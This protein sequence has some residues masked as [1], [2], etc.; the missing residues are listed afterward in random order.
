MLITVVNM[1]L[2][3]NIKRDFYVKFI[4]NRTYVSC[5]SN[6]YLHMYQNKVSRKAG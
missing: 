6:H 5:L 3:E 4:D 1:K 2:A